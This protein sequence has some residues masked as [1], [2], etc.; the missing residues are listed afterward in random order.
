VRLRVA[1]YLFV[2]VD[3][4]YLPEGAPGD[5][6]AAAQ[7]PAGPVPVRLQE[8]RKIKLNEV[9]YF[10]HPLFGVIL[11]VSRMGGEDASTTED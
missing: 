7:P 1:R 11:Q 8:T 6:A 2:D 10:D 5:P 4:A 9:H 3:V